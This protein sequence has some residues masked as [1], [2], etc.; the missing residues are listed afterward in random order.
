MD[1]KI[2]LKRYVA[3]DDN[4]PL[5]QK[6]VWPLT[7]V[8]KGTN[9]DDNIFVYHKGGLALDPVVGDVFECVT[10][11]SQLSEI[12]KGR[13]LGKVIDGVPYYRTNELSFACR[14]AEEADRIWSDV[15]KEVQTLMKNINASNRLREI[16]TAEITEDVEES[17]TSDMSAPQRYQIDYRPAGDATFDDPIQGIENPDEDLM[18]WL[19]VSEAPTGWVKPPGAVLFYNIT[20]DSGLKAIW[21][22]KE[23]LSG[24]QFFIDGLLLHYGVTHAFTDKTVWWLDFDPINMA[25][26]KRVAPQMANANMP[27]PTDFISRGS[28]GAY[29]PILTLSLFL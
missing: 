26:F 12:P 20:K 19:P 8:A 22:P 13:S 27:W 21:P 23:P 16:S 9:V 6:Q 24:N 5:P 2:T 15:V 14:T 18:G 1:A 3:N 29:S 25:L 28:P 10:S 17:L 11:V 7:I 4:L